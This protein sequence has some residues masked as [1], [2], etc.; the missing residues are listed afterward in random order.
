MAPLGN[1][2]LQCCGSVALVPGAALLSVYWPSVLDRVDIVGFGGTDG[3]GDGTPIGAGLQFGTG[4]M[5]GGGGCLNTHNN[6]TD[7]QAATPAPRNSHSPPHPCS[8]TPLISAAGVVNAARYVAGPISPGELVAIFGSNL[9]PAA[10][11]TLQLTPSGS[12][13][14][15]SLSGTRV[16]FDGNA[17]PMI[18]TSAGQVNVVSPFA[19]AGKSAT[20]IQVEYNGIKSDSVT[21]PV[22]NSASGIFTSLSTGVGPAAALNQDSSVNW[23]GSA[24]DPGSVLVLYA[25]GAG[26]TSP[27]GI[28]G[29]I[30]AGGSYTPV[31][32]VG[33]KIGG[34]DAEIL[35]SGSAP[36]L[37]AGIVQLKARVPPGLS[38]RQSVTLSAGGSVSQA[39]VNISTTIDEPIP[40][41][42]MRVAV[43]ASDIVYDPGSN[44][45]Y[46]SIPA[47]ATQNANSVAVIDPNAGQVVDW[48]QTG[49]DPRLLALSD[50]GH[51]LY[52]GLAQNSAIQ[53]ID[54]R[55]KISDFTLQLQ[56][57]YSDQLLFGNLVL[58]IRDM[59]SLPGQP[60]SLAITAVSI[61]GS[62]MLP[63]AIIDDEI[64]RP[65]LGPPTSFI[66]PGGPGFAW[67]NDR[68]LYFAASGI[69]PGPINAPLARLGL[70]DSR[71]IALSDRLVNVSGYVTSTAG[72]RL[73]GE[74]PV[75]APN[76]PLADF[77]ATHPDTG[78]V[79]FAGN[80]ACGGVS[81]FAF[82]PVTFSPA[83]IFVSDDCHN[84]ANLSFN[85]GLAEHLIPVGDAGFAVVSSN[86]PIPNTPISNG[87]FIIPF[88]LLSP[89]L[90]TNLP[91]S[92][93][94]AGTL[95]SF[96]I[97]GNAI[98][99]D[100]AGSTLYF[101]LPGVLPGIGN[102][103]VPFDVVAGQFGTPVWLG[104]EPSVGSVSTDG[105]YLHLALQ[106][107]RE[108]VRLKLP[109][110][111]TDARFPFYDS[112]GFLPVALQVFSLPSEPKSIVL[113][114]VSEGLILTSAGVAIY[115]DG[116]RRSSVALSPPVDAAQVSS[117]GDSM[118]GQDGQDTNLSLSRWSIA[119]DGFHLQNSV[120]GQDGGFYPALA[121]QNDRCVNGNGV[122]FDSTSLSVI[123]TLTG[124]PLF[125]GVAIFRGV[126]LMDL[127]NNRI[128]SA[129]QYSTGTAVQ[130]FEATTYMVTGIYE[131]PEFD[132]VQTLLKVN[133]DQLALWNG[134]ELLLLPISMLN[135]H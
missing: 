87:V 133:G 107:S 59:K 58:E 73:L 55:S 54:L 26:Q 98:T 48:I 11:A 126:P 79:Y 34:Q 118:V 85:Y 37:V 105:Q 82:N 39:E 52:A 35:Y 24:A 15:N 23:A 5:R 125:G 53:R 94:A 86:G 30:A 9:G 135:S 128:F 41:A 3:S 132:G 60:G 84:P 108:V 47:N 96:P 103:V 134:A 77:V 67:A 44:R 22:A 14:T 93:P 114:T 120:G 119:P 7:F 80:A 66:T 31:L 27:P 33:V 89:Q 112:N 70:N 25:T 63:S 116:I 13:V 104:S 123:T 131:I 129:S 72:D 109:G 69:R 91:A 51:Y 56:D 110:L 92:N 78:F 49:A 117:T 71:I 101:S 76:A 28:D 121:C 29:S 75:A 17:A 19:L 83:G 20:T 4:F 106:G 16:L 21:I 10:G 122:V 18:Y 113:S 40:Q 130:S 65:A 12:S 8:T 38:G 42:Y 74:L 88:S 127:D 57:I 100:A 97:L 64:R 111:T 45:L 32:P 61:P 62:L 115:D 50:D 2:E 99:P 43:E 36:G 90:A 102:S 46:A 95:R 6:A 124:A 81:L 68:I 1:G